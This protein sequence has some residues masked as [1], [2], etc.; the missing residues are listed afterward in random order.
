MQGQADDDCHR[1]GRRQHALD[2]QIEDIGQRGNDRDQEN[3]RPQQV[4]QQPAGVPYPLHHHRTDQHGQGARREQPPGDLQTGR[5]QVQ[6]HVLRPGR[7]LHRVQPL[8]EQ[9]RAEQ[10]EHQQPHQQLPLT[11]AAADHAPQQQVEQ[12]QRQGGV[13]GMV[14]EQ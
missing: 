1:T 10:R 13:Q 6:R 12:H 7:R 9:H 2:R 8:I 3:H 11:A 14:G 5:R 4:L